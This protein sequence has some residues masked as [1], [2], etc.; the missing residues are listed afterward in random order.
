[1]LDHRE[2][3]AYGV[4]VARLAGIALVAAAVVLAVASF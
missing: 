4:A 1:V 2:L 3:S